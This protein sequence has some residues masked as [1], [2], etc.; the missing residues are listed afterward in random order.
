M[1]WLVM[2]MTATEFPGGSFEVILDKGCL[3]ALMGEEGAEAEKVGDKFLAEVSRLLKPGGGRYL[4]VTLAQEHVLSLLLKKFRT[5]EWDIQILRVPL[6]D[7]STAPGAP[8]PV[9]SLHPYLVLA[10]HCGIPPSPSCTPPIPSGTPPVPSG[11]PPTPSGAPS[12]ASSAPTSHDALGTDG[13][14]V[15]QEGGKHGGGLRAVQL[16]FDTIPA[17]G[18]DPSQLADILIVVDRENH[19]RAAL[20]QLAKGSHPDRTQGSTASHPGSAS[21]PTGGDTVTGL[22][23]SDAALPGFSDSDIE[24]LG[25]V[26]PGRRMVRRLG[27]ELGLSAG[28]GGLRV[29]ADGNRSSESKEQD[30]ASES[31]ALGPRFITTVLD[32]KPGMVAASGSLPCAVFLVPQ[33]R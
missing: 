5:L 24:A 6:P 3:D 26:I 2:D 29:S 31:E 32:A 33:V 14:G 21:G 22:P 16:A 28:T 13:N 10:T 1:E 19:T 30:P 18:A 20:G 7:P 23:Y 27:P 4:C 15:L 8:S 17:P 12:P 25:R 9:S 11:T